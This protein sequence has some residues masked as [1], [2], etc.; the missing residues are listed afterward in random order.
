[1]ETMLMADEE[2][3]ETDA[4]DQKDWQY[5]VDSTAA[6]AVPADVDETAAVDG[7]STPPP[8]RLR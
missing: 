7:G 1:M 3:H 8:T 2:L 4:Q 6:D 5:E